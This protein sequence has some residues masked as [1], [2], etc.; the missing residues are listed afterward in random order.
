MILRNA[1]VIEGTGAPPIG[2]TYVR[3]LELTTKDGIVYDTAELLAD[4]RKMVDETWKDDNADRPV[5]M[6]PGR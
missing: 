1:I 4:V 2:P 5:A 6:N 3:G